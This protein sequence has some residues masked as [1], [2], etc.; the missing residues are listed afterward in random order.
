MVAAQARQVQRHCFCFDAFSVR[1]AFSMRIGIHPGSRRGRLSLE[2]AS[3]KR[4]RRAPSR[5]AAGIEDGAIS[6]SAVAQAVR[7]AFPLI[8]VV[9]DHARRLHGGLA[10]LGIAGNLALDA[11]AFGMQQ[12]AQALELG[13]QI[14]DF[15]ER[16]SGDALDQRV[17]VVD[18]GFGIG[19]KRRV[20][21]AGRAGRRAAQIGDVVA[22]EIADAGLD[23]R[24]RGEVGVRLSRF[25]FFRTN[26][27]QRLFSLFRVCCERGCPPH[28]ENEAAIWAVDFDRIAT[29]MRQCSIIHETR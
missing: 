8:H 5:E 26:G 15:G 1:D 24:G 12:V 25:N 7:G 4:N 22:D 13:N 9:G 28:D 17:D 14:F 20:S 23:F 11:L 16:G 27:I 29:N 6:E 3:T 19:L 10:E 2:S 21:A 18:G